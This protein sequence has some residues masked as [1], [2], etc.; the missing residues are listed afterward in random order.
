MKDKSEDPDFIRKK[1]GLYDTS[2]PFI[3]C[4]S[5]VV[6]E[7][8]LYNLEEDPQKK[9]LGSAASKKAGITAI[10]KLPFDLKKIKRTG[11][12]LLSDDLFLNTCWSAGEQHSAFK[13]DRKPV[14]KE[15]LT[16][17]N[18]DNHIL[19][20]KFESWIKA[21]QGYFFEYRININLNDYYTLAIDIDTLEE[22]LA[23]CASGQNA[24]KQKISKTIR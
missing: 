1:I 21:E 9:H 4:I 17:T 16:N 10:V 13:W 3:E 6:L 7:N 19:V 2:K 15:W 18:I 23:R 5:N 20:L 14:T 12:P 24:K 11:D 8:W 22:E